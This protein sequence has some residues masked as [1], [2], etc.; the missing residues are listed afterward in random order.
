MAARPRRRSIDQMC[1]SSVGKGI[2]SVN[3][4]DSVCPDGW[5]LTK[6]ISL[7]RKL[8]GLHLR[9]CSQM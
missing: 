3:L 7:V 6:N 4:R 8:S 5:I 9:F 1:T 2:F